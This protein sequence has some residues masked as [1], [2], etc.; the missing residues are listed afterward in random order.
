MD[1]N[2]AFK[3]GKKGQGDGEFNEPGCLSV[4]K[5]GHLMVCDSENHRVQVFEISG[6]FVTK[7]GI[8]GSKA[9]E[10]NSPVSTAVLKDGRIVVSDFRNHRIQIFE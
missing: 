4:N 6:K 9:G 8:K 3:I 5:A 2:V 1:G 10:L 7:F